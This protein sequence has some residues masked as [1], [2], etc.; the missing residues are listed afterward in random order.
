MSRIIS[1][2]EN[3]CA[4][5]S[6]RLDICHAVDCKLETSS[7]ET[8]FG[9]RGHLMIAQLEQSMNSPDYRPAKPLWE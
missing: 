4:N 8:S 9:G 2:A 5:V 1:N 3:I 6:N 7:P